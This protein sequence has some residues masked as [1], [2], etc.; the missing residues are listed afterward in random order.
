MAVVARHDVATRTGIGYGVV[1]LVH[2]VF[3]LLATQY[4]STYVHKELTVV[5]Q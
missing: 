2:I 3:A 5:M 4:A 1:G